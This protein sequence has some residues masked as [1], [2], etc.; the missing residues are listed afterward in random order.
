MNMKHWNWKLVIPF[1][2]LFLLQI[3]AVGQSQ[4]W[5]YGAGGGITI[6]PNGGVTD[7]GSSMSTGEGCASIQDNSGEVLFYTNAADVYDKNG[8]VVN[9]GGPLFGASFH[10]VSAAQGAAILPLGDCNRFLILGA[11]GVESN[12][13]SSGRTAKGFGI[14]YVTVDDQGVVTSS[15]ANAAKI[16]TQYTLSEK[17]SILEKDGVYSVITKELLPGSNKY[18]KWQL[19][20]TDLNAVNSLTDAISLF[21]T[22]M[23]SQE[24][25]RPFTTGWSLTNTSRYYMAQGQLK[26]SSDGTKL[27]HVYCGDRVIEL[28][29]FDPATGLLSNSRTYNTNRVNLYGFEF[30]RSGDRFFVTEHYQGTQT[31]NRILL[32]DYTNTAINSPTTLYTAANYTN[33]A[34]MGLQIGIDD[35]I[36][37]MGKYFNTIVRIEGADDANPSLST[38]NFGRST[39]YALPLFI[40]GDYTCKDC[41]NSNVNYNFVCT[42]DSTTLISTQAN[43]ATYLWNNG[44]T[45]NYIS[46]KEGG[47]YT[48]TAT[49]STCVL[50]DTFYV[51][52]YVPKRFTLAKDTL[53]CNTTNLNIYGPTAT[54]HSWSNGESKQNISVNESGI[55]TLEII[56]SNSCTSKDS[57]R[58]TFSQQEFAILIQDTTMCDSIFELEY[59]TNYSTTLWNDT[60]TKQSFSA[61]DFGSYWLELTDSNGCL[62]KDTFTILRGQ[63]PEFELDTIFTCSGEEVSITLPSIYTVS[64][65]DGDTNRTKTLNYVGN[66]PYT[67]FSSDGCSLSQVAVVSSNSEQGSIMYIPNAFSPNNDGI[68]NTFPGLDNTIYLD[69][70]SLQ[71]FNRW[72][73][74]L[75]ETFEI[76]NWDGTYKNKICQQD[77]Y[78]YLISFRDCNGDRQILHGTVTMLP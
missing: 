67:L 38:N 5:P 9:T 75:F 10:T 22:K 16:L 23:Q 47:V 46:A 2:S 43:P 70:F 26:F 1:C 31:P 72:G 30:S 57:I 64:W 3:Y 18:F 35:N 77:T 13:G 40:S 37:V 34:F 20:T 68:N 58:V 6:Q 29:D 12:S 8:T 36:Y 49:S 76:R 28:F 54:S 42:G 14:A 27:G 45:T 25:G 73:E 52:E 56:D 51:E 78:V 74:K 59:T 11:P 17:L 63:N 4:F 66:Y 53:L 32:F 55:Y 60:L 48:C 39:G 7:V 61:T 19:S 44:Q 65:F 62:L 41:R 50:T 33:Y 71:I 24:V 69:N 21:E 15:A